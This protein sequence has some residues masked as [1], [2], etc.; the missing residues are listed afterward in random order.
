MTDDA[1]IGDR[2][3]RHESALRA[4]LIV[5]ETRLVTLLIAANA[6]SL[7]FVASA[8]VDGRLKADF[9]VSLMAGL[10][11]LGAVIGF[12]GSFLTYF[13][14]RSLLEVL[15]KMAIG[16]IHREPQ[17]DEEMKLAYQILD[18]F[19]STEMR[20]IAK[21]EWFVSSCYIASAMCWIGGVSMGFIFPLPLVLH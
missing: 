15:T 1:K 5:H 19:R 20:S 6:A 7:V 16:R 2:I 12:V 14:G 9:P 13:M 3:A 11:A 8:I 21:R 18:V 10:F 17:P 4:D